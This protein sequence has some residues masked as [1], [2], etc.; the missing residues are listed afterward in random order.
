MRTT[1]MPNRSIKT[2]GALL[3]C[4]SAG[5]LFGCTEEPKQVRPTNRPFKGQPQTETE[6]P[7]VENTEERGEDIRRVCT[8]KAQTSTDISR[9]WM[10]ESE[11]RGAKKFDAEIKLM[12]MIGPEGKA[13]EIKVLNP[14]TG[15]LTLESCVVEAV[16]GW[17]FPAG[18]TV[19]PAQCNFLL[20][21][22]M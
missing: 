22:M 20:R 12:L 6:T 21:P 16:R 17:N 13:Q 1:S 14:V 19:A 8:R 5:M 15:L 4:L 2:S 18:Q 3:L 10:E 7:T 11:R 9:C